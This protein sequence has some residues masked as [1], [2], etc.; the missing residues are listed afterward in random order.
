[1]KVN[2][3]RSGVYR[4]HDRFYLSQR[5]PVYII[6]YELYLAIGLGDILYDSDGNRFKVTGK[7]CHTICF[8]EPT[9]NDPEG[10]LFEMMDGKEAKGGVLIKEP[11]SVLRPG[12]RTVMSEDPMPYLGVEDMR[13]DLGK[14]R[15]T[16]E[17]I[18]KYATA[19]NKFWFMEDSVC[20]YK[21]HLDESGRLCH[22]AGE[23]AEI[24]NDLF[25]RVMEEA[26]I[27][28]FLYDLQPEK[29]YIKQISRIMDKYGYY[30]GDGW[31]LVRNDRR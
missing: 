13:R 12:D 6:D 15:S 24:M 9:G 28:G 22:E 29:G 18:D 1:M 7:E 11:D 10:V 14:I 5:G 27:E 26:D 23:W 21:K 30:D 8:S 4:I 2:K 20:E 19:H 31:W 3:Y 25:N 17:L 16:P